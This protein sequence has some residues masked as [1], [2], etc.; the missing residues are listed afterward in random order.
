MPRNLPVRSQGRRAVWLSPGWRA[1]VFAA[2]G[3]AVGAALVVAR[4]ANATSYLSES[5]EACINCHVM[6]DAYASWQ[7]G[8]HG[9]VAGCVDCHVPHSN[10]VAGYAFKGRDGARHSW[11]FTLRR[12]PQVLRLSA[13][14][15][16]VVQSNCVRCHGRQLEM[17]RLA[18]VGER[19]CWDCHNNVHG[20]VQSLSSSPEGLRPPLPR[21]AP[22]WLMKGSTE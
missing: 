8:S 6:T 14:A 3:A 17:V 16:P 11:V 13:G 9:L 5:P 19:P 7:R 21:A 2:A 12:E 10:A 1:A 15:V 22:A 4:I 18:P 20:R